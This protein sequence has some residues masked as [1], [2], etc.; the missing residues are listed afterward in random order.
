MKTITLVNDLGAQHRPLK[1]AVK[2]CDDFW[3]NIGMIRGPDLAALQ[4]VE[5]LNRCRSNLAL[6]NRKPD[7][8]K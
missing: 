1:V 7:C 5:Q 2:A 8:W 3:S 4:L 6:S